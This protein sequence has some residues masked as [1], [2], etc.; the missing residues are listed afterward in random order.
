MG[1][2]MLVMLLPSVN[3]WSE[4]ISK[5]HP[6]V[7]WITEGFTLIVAFKLRSRKTNWGILYAYLWIVIAAAIHGYFKSEYYWDWKLLVSNLMTY[8]L[9]LI[10]LVVID[11]NKTEKILGLWYKWIPIIIVLLFFF[12]DEP[13]F[14]G[15]LMVPYSLLLI[16]LPILNKRNRVLCY[17]A[18]AVVFIMARTDRSDTIRFVVALL[19]GLSCYQNFYIH[20]KKYIKPLAIGLLISP[21]ILFGLAIT[22]TFNILNIG[23]EM[24]L[25]YR[26]EVESGHSKNLF[27]D[28]RTFLFEEEILSSVKH[29]YWLF[30]RS[31]ARGYDSIFFGKDIKKDLDWNRTE[32]QYCET[33][34]LNVFNYMGIV[35]VIAFSCVI[36]GAVIKAVT[37][38][39]NK[40][41][42]IL[43]L[44]LA[45]RFFYTWLE[46]FQRF[47]TNYVLFWIIVGL[48]YSPQFR[49]CNNAQIKSVINRITN[50]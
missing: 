43:G 31:L 38:S 36:F 7:W 48:C 47:D 5:I 21:F 39:N 40:Y 12:G 16:F 4:V 14:Y 13:H 23:E 20:F 32:R 35:G 10:S 28:D 1:I 15:R 45:F 26:Y 33:G 42:P 3:Q 46:E 17:I 8:L 18:F 24:G 6:I 25:E 27:S 2:A 49:S 50:Y 30:G 34:I 11:I 44:Y 41:I 22:G 29:N 37:E 19:L 9:P